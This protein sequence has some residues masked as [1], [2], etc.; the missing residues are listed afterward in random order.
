[1]GV[2]VWGLGVGV[3]GVGFGVFGFGFWVLGV[4]VEVLG[5]GFGVRGFGFGVWG[6]EVGVWGLG[7][8]VWGLGSG[9][10]GVG[11][12]V[13]VLGGGVWGSG[14]RRQQREH[15]APCASCTLPPPTPQGSGQGRAPARREELDVHRQPRPLPL[16]PPLGVALARAAP[17]ARVAGGRAVG[18]RRAPI[19]PAGFARR[20]GLV[21]P[22]ERR[23]QR[24]VALLRVIRRRAVLT[25]LVPLQPRHKLGL[26]PPDLQPRL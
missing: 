2:G 7:F 13:R 5:L 22:M 20:S 21:D 9:R 4:G 3:S 14:S 1:M 10:W 6:L 16:F 11:F 15:T 23:H 26:L 19:L 8:G 24:S 12:G 17:P 18:G 25:R